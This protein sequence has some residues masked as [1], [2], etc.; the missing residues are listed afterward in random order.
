M[1]VCSVLGKSFE[2]SGYLTHREAFHDVIDV[3]ALTPEDIDTMI[4]PCKPFKRKSYGLGAS[5][6]GVSGERWGRVV[7]EEWDCWQLHTGRIAK[8]GTENSKWVW[9]EEGEVPAEAME[10]SAEKSDLLYIKGLGER[11]R[12]NFSVFNSEYIAFHPYQCLPLY[13]I[14]YEL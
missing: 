7:G 4:E 12:V 13:E 1:I 14:E 8:K 10:T 6:V 5:I 3:R 9:S 11:T 2:I